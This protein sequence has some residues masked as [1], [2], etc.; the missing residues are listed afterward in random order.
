MS[1]EEWQ[2]IGLTLRIA[3]ASVII[4][5]PFA[6]AVAMLLS[7]GRFP[8]KILLEALVNLPLVLPPV[9]TGYALLL[10]FGRIGPIGRLLDECCGIVLSRSMM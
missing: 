1:P 3:A 9:V 5:L 4:G 7:R 2:I 10:L 6:T 8:G